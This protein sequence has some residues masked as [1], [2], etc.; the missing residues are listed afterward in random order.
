MQSYLII[1]SVIVLNVLFTAFEIVNTVRVT[2]CIK[3]FLQI[4][5]CLRRN[6]L[7]NS[8]IHMYAK[9]CAFFIPRGSRN[10]Y[11]E[12]EYHACTC[13]WWNQI[14]TLTTIIYSHSYSTFRRVKF[15][16]LITT[17]ILILFCD[18]VQRL[19][20]FQLAFYSGFCSNH[21]KWQ[22]CCQ[23]YCWLR[24]GLL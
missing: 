23:L 6:L 8:S 15:P 21:H 1:T 18:E 12:K 3:H 10:V 19:Q 2:L 5:K 17:I 16:P 9:K 13:K 4:I 7:N 14:N 20:S 11:L 24:W 22:Q